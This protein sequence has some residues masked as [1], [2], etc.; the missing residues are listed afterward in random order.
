MQA[1]KLLKNHN[2]SIILHSITLV[3][4]TTKAN[5]VTVVENQGHTLED[6]PLFWP[7]FQRSEAVS[8][9]RT[10]VL[11]PI[12]SSLYST[13]AVPSGPRD[14]YV[15][16]HRCVCVSMSIYLCNLPTFT[17]SLGD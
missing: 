17:K 14:I 7:W 8:L 10:L 5:R 6:H 1:N 3:S 13:G 15:S 9:Y 12:Q 2:V 16:G 4:H 11:G